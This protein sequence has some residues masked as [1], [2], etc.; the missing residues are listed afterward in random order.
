MDA[1]VERLETFRMMEPVSVCFAIR[2]LCLLK[3]KQ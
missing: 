3:K 1:A 2:S